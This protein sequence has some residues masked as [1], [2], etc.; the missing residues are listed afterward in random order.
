MVIFSRTLCEYYYLRLNLIINN[1]RDNNVTKCDEHEVCFLF[2]NVFT[3]GANIVEIAVCLTM[4]PWSTASILCFHIR[5]GST[6][7]G[8]LP[9]SYTHLDVYKRQQ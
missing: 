6:I 9:V 5:F 7:E 1:N 2:P 3:A 4:R 8:H